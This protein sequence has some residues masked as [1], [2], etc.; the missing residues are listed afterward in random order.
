MREALDGHGKGLIKV[1]FMA[2]RYKQG[3]AFFLAAQNGANAVFAG[4]QGSGGSLC[5]GGFTVLSGQPGLC[6]ADGGHVEQHAEMRRDAKPSRVSNS[7][8][9]QHEYI[10]AER[11]F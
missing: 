3:V 11:Q 5:S 2:G 7:L 1:D 10:R 9:I 6:N 8:P 4:D